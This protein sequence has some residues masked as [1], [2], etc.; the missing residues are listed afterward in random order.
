MWIGLVIAVM[1]LLQIVSSALVG[2]FL[3][4]IGG[5]NPIILIGSLLIIIQ[6]ATLMYLDY[7]VDDTRFLYLSFIA[8]ILGGATIGSTSG[9]VAHIITAILVGIAESRVR[10]EFG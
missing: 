7:E 8:Q 3:H 6:T 4:V 5:R 1:A 9:R 2:K 10:W